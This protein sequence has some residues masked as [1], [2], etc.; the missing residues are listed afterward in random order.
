MGNMEAGNTYEMYAVAAGVIGGI[1]PLGGTG[2]LLGTLGGAAVWQTLENG[3]NMIGAQVGIQRIVIGVIVVFAVLLDVV[4]R[5]ASSAARA[6]K[7]RMNC[8]RAFRNRNR[9]YRL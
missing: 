7:R 4:F 3:L 1:S 6:P 8:L 9:R 5:A 2:L